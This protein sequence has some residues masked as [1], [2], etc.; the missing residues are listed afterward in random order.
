MGF[1]VEA[2][3]RDMMSWWM[4]TAISG[5]RRVVVGTRMRVLRW[6]MGLL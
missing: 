2:G 3:A 4:R 5:R 6:G 1:P